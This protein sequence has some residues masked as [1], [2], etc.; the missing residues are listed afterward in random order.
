MSDLIML[1]VSKDKSEP[2]VCSEQ[3]FQR[4]VQGFVK[5]CRYAIRKGYK[6]Y[7]GKRMNRQPPKP[8]PYKAMITKFPKEDDHP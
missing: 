8:C 1:S 6:T 3:A 2:L 4:D 7:C 5:K